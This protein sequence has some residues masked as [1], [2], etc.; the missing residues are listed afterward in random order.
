MRLSSLC[1]FYSLLMKSY[2]LSCWCFLS[3]V[4]FDVCRLVLHQFY[5]IPKPAPWL[6]TVSFLLS[7]QADMPPEYGGGMDGH[8]RSASRQ[9]HHSPQQKR[10]SAPS[11]ASHHHRGSGVSG[12]G[13][14][15]GSKSGIN[16]SGG[17]LPGPGA[18]NP[19]QSGLGYP[20][21]TTCAHNFPIFSLSLCRRAC[22]LILLLLI[23]FNGVVAFILYFFSLR[24]CSFS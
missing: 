3:F 17:V 2:F 12:L 10:T 11:T 4:S 23:L 19:G 5:S 16:G 7:L 8:Q 15:L 1:L 9:E 24:Q 21:K 20:G 22:A 13:S 6:I 18:Y 14:G